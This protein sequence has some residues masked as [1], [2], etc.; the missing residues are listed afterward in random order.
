MTNNINTTILTSTLEFKHLQSINSKHT[1]FILREGSFQM[2]FLNSHSNVSQ[3]QTVHDVS[4][5][6]RNIRQLRKRNQ[7]SKKN[8]NC[9]TMHHIYRCGTCF[10]LDRRSWC[11]RLG[12]W[13]CFLGCLVWSFIIDSR[14]NVIVRVD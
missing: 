7:H 5:R 13:S 12:G 4:S 10:F 8:G 2:D 6:T 11:R 3:S 14:R 1:F 9:Q